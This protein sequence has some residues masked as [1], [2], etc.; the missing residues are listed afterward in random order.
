MRAKWPK[1]HPTAVPS[2]KPPAKKLSTTAHHEIDCAIII[3]CNTWSLAMDTIFGCVILCVCNNINSC[4]CVS[5]MYS[6]NCLI[7]SII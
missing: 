5:S 1:E 6:V 3:R 2:Y 4:N 7:I